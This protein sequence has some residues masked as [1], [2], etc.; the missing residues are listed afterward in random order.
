MSCL[1]LHNTSHV[2]GGLQPATSTTGPCLDSPVRMLCRAVAAAPACA[3]LTLK[4]N[5]CTGSSVFTNALHS[6]LGLRLLA[7][8]SFHRPRTTAQPNT[9]NAVLAAAAGVE[10]LVMGG[11]GAGL[12]WNHDSAA[13]TCKNDA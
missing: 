7:D 6:Q 3:S 10:A 11:P 8:S 13:A 5:S 9:S 4:S 12:R 1:H 2:C